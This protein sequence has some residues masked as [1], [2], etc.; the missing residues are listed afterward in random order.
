[1][2]Y[3]IQVCWQFVSRIICFCSQAVSKPVWHIP[4]LGVQ[5][6]TPDD[7]QRNCPKHVEFHSKNKFEKLVHLVGFIVR[8]V[9]RRMVTWTSNSLNPSI[10]KSYACSLIMKHFV[11]STGKKKCMTMQNDQR[12]YCICMG[13][14]NATYRMCAKPQTLDNTQV[15][16]G[17]F[18]LLIKNDNKH[19]VRS[20]HSP[21]QS[22][23]MSHIP[24][25]TSF[26][27]GNGMVLH[28]YQQQESSTTKTVHKVINR[29]L[30]T[31]V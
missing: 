21:S 24:Y 7:G 5:W 30:K 10:K 1:M 18:L 16:N 2:V 20:P 6:K 29:G 9:S 23:R 19:I 11:P 25:P 28:F 27:Y 31:Y 22:A 12:R 13:H 4:L 8:N 14:N 3:V 17:L 15:R 26:P